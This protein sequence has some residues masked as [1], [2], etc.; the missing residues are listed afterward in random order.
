MIEIERVQKLND[1]PPRGGRFVLYWMQASQRSS[2]N[3]ALQYAIERARELD[4]PV[5]AAFGLTASFPEANARHLTFML[6]GL[7]KT[8]RELAARGI[9]LAIRPS[10]PPDVVGELSVEA[11]LTVTDVGYLRLQRQWRTAAAERCRS[12][13]V[14]VEDEVIVPTGLVSAKEEWAARTI[15]PRIQRHLSR[16]LRPRD[17]QWPRRDSLPVSL[18]GPDLDPSDPPACLSRIGV[19]LKG[20]PAAVSTFRGGP[21]EARSRL[22]EFV[23]RKL[24]RYHLDRGNPGLE[25]QSE[26]SP[27][28]H[29]GQISARE[30][31]LAVLDAKRAPEEARAAFLE[32]LVVR[33]EL[34][35]NFCIHNEQYDSWHCLPDWARSSLEAHSGDARPVCYSRDDLESGRTHD[36]YW[37]AAMR[38][39]AVTGKMHNYMRMYW[40]KKILEWTSDPRQ[41][42]ATALELN[43]RYSLDGRDPNSFAGVAWCFGKHDQ[44]WKE[45]EIFGKIRYMN[46]AGLD[47]KFD[48]PAYLSRVGGL[49]TPA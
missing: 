15:R 8:G 40:G 37:N 23:E 24:P 46:S 3:G 18:P 17:E 45:R 26:L 12:L 36:P 30:V 38:E 31:A 1:R 6:E 49:G 7:A 35:A 27:Y 25:I 22:L 33:R 4:L 13:L 9:R 2:A 47:R 42:F 29:F 28:L 20:A 48:M 11:A 14:A 39:L 5:L 44:A 34:S 41:A 43:N 21:S 10:A 19:S 16:F 32:E